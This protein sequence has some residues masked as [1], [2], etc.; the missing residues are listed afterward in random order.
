[1]LG[2]N[3][4][5]RS[6]SLVPQDKA[7]RD[8]FDFSDVLARSM[9]GSLGPSRDLNHVAGISEAESV[10]SLTAPPPVRPSGWTSQYY[11]SAPLPS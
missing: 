11:L 9:I 10:D 4:K 1:M 3:G 6:K 8:I 2:D 7:T 5:K